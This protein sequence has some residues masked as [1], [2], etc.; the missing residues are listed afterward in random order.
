MGGFH[1]SCRPCWAHLEVQPLSF[2]VMQCEFDLW[3]YHTLLSVLQEHV[4]IPPVGQNADLAEKIAKPLDLFAKRG[5]LSTP[6]TS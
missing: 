2:A 5:R 3:M 4:A 6:E 1:V